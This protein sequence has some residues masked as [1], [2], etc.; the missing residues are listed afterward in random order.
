VISPTARLGRGIAIM[1]GA[2]LN[3]ETVVEDFAVINTRASVDH[4][5]RIGLAAHIA[6]GCSLAG[7]VSVGE[8]AFLGAGVTVIPNRT[9]G[10]D[11]QVGAGA[12]V[13]SDLVEPGL[14]LG[15]PARRRA[16]TL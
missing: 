1:A 5:G 7:C 11:I 2:V 3:A 10:A 9:I 4:D 15:V 14:Y 13:V 6:P 8:R 12:C 16:V